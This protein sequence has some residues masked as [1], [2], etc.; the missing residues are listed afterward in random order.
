MYVMTYTMD[1]FYSL[2]YPSGSTIF[3]FFLHYDCFQW[4][5]F[6]K[7]IIYDSIYLDGLVIMTLDE[8][9]QRISNQL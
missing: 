3:F 5:I 6:P 9:I 2:Y 1:I 8:Y 4:K 7:S